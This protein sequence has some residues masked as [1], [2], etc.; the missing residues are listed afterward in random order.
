VQQFEVDICPFRD[1]LSLSVGEMEAPDGAIPLPGRQGAQWTILRLVLGI[2][3]F[4]FLE[5]NYHGAIMRLYEVKHF[6]TLR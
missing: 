1:S 2:D 6:L 3:R 4:K 5:A